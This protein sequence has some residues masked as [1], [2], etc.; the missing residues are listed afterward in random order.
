M[1]FAALVPAMPSDQHL[2]S[3]FTGSD[4]F[5]CTLAV[6]SCANGAVAKLRMQANHARLIAP[7][8]LEFALDQLDP[9]SGV[10]LS[11]K[12][13]AVVEVHVVPTGPF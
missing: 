8:I 9:R 2:Q 1:D 7:S 5:V 3:R 6:A 11:Q 12:A 13:S 4:Q 10:R